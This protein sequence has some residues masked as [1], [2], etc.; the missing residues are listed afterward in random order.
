MRKHLLLLCLSILVGG[1]VK[2]QSAV[3]YMQKIDENYK[4]ISK[5]MWDYTSTVAHSK[6]GKKIDQTRQDLITSIRGARIKVKRM[7]AYEGN[8][9]YRDSVIKFLDLQEIVLTKN[10]EKIL[11]MEEIAEQSYDLMEAYLLAQK[12]AGKIMDA[13]SDMLDKVEEEFAAEHDI[14]LIENQSKLGKKL[15]KASDVYDYYN[16]VYLIFFKVYK[17]EAY[18]NK[19]IA[20]NDI[21]GME[22]NRKTLIKEAESA[23]EKLKPIGSFD[24]DATLRKA[25]MDI[26]QFYKKE[27]EKDAKVISDFYLKKE[28]FE[29]LKEAF[30]KKKK[31]DRT[32]EDVDKINKA[33][34]EYN[35]A[36]KEY[37]T[38]VDLVNKERS[39]MLKAWNSSVT[40]FFKR[41]IS[42]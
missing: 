22:Q 35:A 42:R 41:H 36:V 29:K 39:K 8:S 27:G 25:C 28:T 40:R 19:A 18:L 4:E 12:E 20:E 13:A 31:K 15:A 9:A 1:F 32:Q 33:G 34:E 17:Q 5:K 38:V 10:Y 37:N 14:N 30:D 16:P 23:I 3:E 11:D 6:N 21:N 2:G 7:Q 24:D 26:V